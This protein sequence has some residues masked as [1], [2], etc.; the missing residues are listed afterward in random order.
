MRRPKIVP[1]LLLT[2]AGTPGHAADVDVSGYPDLAT[3]ALLPPIGA[4]LK[5]APRRPFN[6]CR[7]TQL[8]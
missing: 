2:C 7:A 1:A 5:R 8:P 6:P 3:E 4:E